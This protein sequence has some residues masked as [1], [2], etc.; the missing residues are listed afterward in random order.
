MCDLI[1][2]RHVPGEPFPSPEDVYNAITNADPE[3]TARCRLAS[4]PDIGGSDLG[5]D[6]S[7][8]DEADSEGR[9]RGTTICD[10]FVEQPYDVIITSTE[11]EQ[12]LSFTDEELWQFPATYPVEDSE[13]PPSGPG[14]TAQITLS[15]GDHPGVL[16]AS[17]YIKFVRV[18]T[19]ASANGEPLE[20]FEVY[21]NLD[22]RFEL[23]FKLH[24]QRFRPEHLEETHAVAFWAV[25]AGKDESEGNWFS[26]E[27]SEYLC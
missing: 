10:P 6:D 3:V 14:M 8:Y 20:V 2:K 1:E 13:P 7:G 11:E 4:S 26:R 24:G 23:S 15:N 21:L 18:W 5:S 17:G 9:F 22:L 27:S 16:A 25:R 19:K 12:S